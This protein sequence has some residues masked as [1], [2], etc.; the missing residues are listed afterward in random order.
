M[1]FQIVDAV[2]SMRSWFSTHQS[3]IAPIIESTTSRII[4]TVPNIFSDTNVQT[5][6]TTVPTTVTSV[7]QIVDAISSI[8]SCF[9]TH[10]SIIAPIIESTTS[11]IIRTFPNIFSDTNVQ[12][13]STTVRTVS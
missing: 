7:L 11:R 10:Q 12:T 5:V 3:I 1:L 6:S 4:R 9:S 8:L 2:S 13:V